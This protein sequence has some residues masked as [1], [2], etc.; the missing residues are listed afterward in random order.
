MPRGS[1]KSD[2]A[3]IWLREHFLDDLPVAELAW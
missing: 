2:H 3:L 1:T